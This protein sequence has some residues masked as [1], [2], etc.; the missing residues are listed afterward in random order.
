LIE[1]EP[2]TAPD[3]TLFLIGPDDVLLT[4]FAGREATVSRRDLAVLFQWL[5]AAA[6]APPAEEVP[7]SSTSSSPR[8]PDEGSYV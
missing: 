8:A 1:R 3:G 2:L 5:F 6:G 4:T 7:C